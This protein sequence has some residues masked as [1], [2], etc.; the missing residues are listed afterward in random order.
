MYLTQQHPST[1]QNE[2]SATLCNKTLA[3]VEM[4]KINGGI[5]YL[6]DITFF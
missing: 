2:K 6:Y 4:T 5:H 3:E 1:N